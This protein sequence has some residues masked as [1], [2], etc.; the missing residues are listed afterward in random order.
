MLLLLIKGHLENIALG[1]I[2]LDGYTHTREDPPTRS[3]FEMCH[4]QTAR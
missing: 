3:E 1:C 2:P 4:L